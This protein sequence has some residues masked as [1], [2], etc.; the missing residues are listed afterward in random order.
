MKTKYGTAKIG[1]NG[2]YVITSVKE[3]NNSAMLHRLVF[4]DYHDCKLDKND[5][6]HH[7][8]G[9][10]LNNHPT[11]LIC[12]SRKA[13]N[14]LHNKWRQHSEETKR[15]MSENHARYWE[16]KTLSEETKKKISE[17]QNT[18]GYFRVTKQKNKTYKQGFTWKYHYY[19]DGKQKAICS[20]SIKKL[21][22]KVKEKGLKWEILK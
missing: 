22:E 3:G 6:I 4:E 1:K 5:V 7:I 9:N 10:P 11:N 18:S 13:H 15:K 20:V 14:L 2:Y 8:D 17:A 12:M 21:E 16:G 19:E